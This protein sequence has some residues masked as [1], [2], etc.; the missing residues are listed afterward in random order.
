MFFTPLTLIRDDLPN[1]QLERQQRLS[2]M[3]GR[4]A[5]SSADM[6]GGEDRTQSASYNMPDMGNLK[7]GVRSVAG[8]MSS[9]M[10]G[11]AST[12]QVTYLDE[13]NKRVGFFHLGVFT[14][15]RSW[16]VMMCIFGAQVNYPLY[17]NVFSRI[18]PVCSVV[19][20]LAL[21]TNVHFAIAKV[22]A[23]D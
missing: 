13:T 3:E 16:S 4:S 22:A 11:I 21:V 7:D 5:I 1:F 18:L 8:K 19:S 17:N 23:Y 10:S 12:I 6:F 15:M 14:G 20:R 2:G 9:V